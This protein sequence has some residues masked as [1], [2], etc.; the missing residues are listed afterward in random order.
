MDLLKVLGNVIHASMQVHLFD[1]NA[2]LG[3]PTKEK[4]F[5]KLQESIEKYALLEA[6]M[7]VIKRLSEEIDN[8]KQQ[9][10]DEN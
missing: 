7:N 2:V 6:Q 4:A 9:N 10:T 1:I 8:S 3:N 5:D